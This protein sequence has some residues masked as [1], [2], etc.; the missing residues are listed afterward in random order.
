MRK[1]FGERAYEHV[2]NW[3]WIL[4]NRKI[5]ILCALLLILIF[6]SSGEDDPE[7]RPVTVE[8][9]AVATTVEQFI[10]QG[11]RNFTDDE[12]TELLPG[13]NRNVRAQD[14][15]FYLD[16]I[17]MELD[18]D[19]NQVREPLLQSNLVVIDTEGTAIF[20]DITFYHAGVYTFRVRQSS[21]LVENET[22]V[23]ASEALI[24]DTHAGATAVY[25]WGVDESDF[26][27][28]VTVIEDEDAEQLRASVNQD[29]VV[30]VNEFTLYVEDI[31]ASLH[32]VASYDE[33][34][35][36]MSSQYALLINLTTGLVLF[37]HQAD[38]RAFPAS[39]TK[40]MTALVGLEHGDMDDSVVV[41][42]DFD[43]LFLS[44]AAQAGFQYGE[45]RP[46]S[47][48]V[49]GVMLPS[50]GDATEALAN[51]IAGSYEAFVHLMNVKARELGMHDTH[52]V[53][54]TGLHDDNHY[55]T[56]YDIATLLRYALEN[57][58]FRE[59]FTREAYE[60]SEPNIFGS[61]M[62]STLFYFA[63]TTEFQG[64]EIIGG[65]T[66]FTFQAGRCLASLATNGEDEFI[67]VTFGAGL[68]NND[69]SAH[70]QDALTI[71]S[72]FLRGDE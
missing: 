16:L 42:A 61:I 21:E 13:L 8:G 10:N 44:E 46:F 12:L 50:G 27:F 19:I 60:L 25:N 17:D 37:E 2:E 9:F 59:M 62:H 40:I 39:V 43:G 29:D 64:G 5:V 71:Y 66:G 6:I 20:E 67:L 26:Y 54:A 23:F 41:E 35:F 4:L 14:F 36:V 15:T 69:Q 32:W 55:T 65:R 33:V 51:H 53:T 47:E 11:E 63:P 57:P 22:L 68:D 45:I 18:A 38:V 28:V 48:I 52:F 7:F 31:L 56:A 24:E 3:V 49:N 72:Y 34:D 70:I 30:F 58:D 1:D